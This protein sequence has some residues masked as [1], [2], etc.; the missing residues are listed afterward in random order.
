M[1]KADSNRMD[2]I[3]RDCGMRI[4]ECGLESKCAGLKSAIHKTH[5]AFACPSLLISFL[6]GALRSSILVGNV[7]MNNLDRRALFTKLADE[8]D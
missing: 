5:S 8:F 4:A 1:F 3:D 6:I 2:R 7:F